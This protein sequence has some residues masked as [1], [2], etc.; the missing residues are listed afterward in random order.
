M[1]RSKPCPAVV[2]C[3]C[4]GLRCR[5]L[6]GAGGASQALTPASC[7]LASAALARF[8]LDRLR[9]RSAMRRTLQY[10]RCRSSCRSACKTFALF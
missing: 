6:V 1:A 4:T 9:D 3:W 7:L 5:Q 10:S 2:S 8:S